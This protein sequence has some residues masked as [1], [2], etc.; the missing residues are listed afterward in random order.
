MPNLKTKKMKF[1]LFAVLP[2]F[3]IAISPAFA[4]EA[5]SYE[6]DEV[7]CSHPR[8]V[9]VD[10]DCKIIRPSPYEQQNGGT[11]AEQ[12][13]CNDD[14]Y[15][16][17]KESDGT[18]F[19]ASGYSINKLISRGFAQA[20]DVTNSAT[21]DKDGLTVK[22]YCPASQERLQWGWYEQTC[23]SQIINTNIDLV[24]DSGEDSYGVEFTFE[25]KNDGKSRVWVFVECDD[26]DATFGGPGNRHPAFLGHYIPDVCTNDMVK[27]LK[28]HSNIFDNDMPYTSPLDGDVLDP[29]INPDD[30]VQCENELLDNRDNEPSWHGNEN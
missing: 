22:E 3:I 19:C 6:L 27:F 16:S 2:I 20:F 10:E 5:G 28:K 9:Q 4:E 8:G 18:A 11:K 13:K 26:F 12:V 15:R 14:L 29:S 25:S 17:Y 30:M 24:Y 23:S 7:W 1:F 21:I